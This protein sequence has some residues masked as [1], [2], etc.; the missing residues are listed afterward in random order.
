MICDRPLAAASATTLML[1]LVVCLQEMP[2][3]APLGQMP[4]S[5]NLILEHDLVDK[6]RYAT[7]RYH[8]PARPL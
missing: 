8:Q 3:R 4:R 6:V 5:I 1:F 7:I 2:E